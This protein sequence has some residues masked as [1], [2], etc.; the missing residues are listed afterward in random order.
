MARRTR[1]RIDGLEK[2]LHSDGYLDLEQDE[3]NAVEASALIKRHITS[4]GDLTS[5]RV[6]DDDVLADLKQA[7]DLGSFNDLKAAVV[8]RRMEQSA[9]SGV[10]S[11]LQPQQVPPAMHTP[12]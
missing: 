7:L 2:Y 4:T 3:R 12:S 8:R 1:R 11:Q 9:S 5:H 6:V 10:N